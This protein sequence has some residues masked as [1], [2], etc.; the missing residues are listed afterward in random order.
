MRRR[1]TISLE[2]PD[3]FYEEGESTSKP[4]WQI[5]GYR[6]AH[7]DFIKNESHVIM[8]GGHKVDTTEFIDPPESDWP[9]MGVDDYLQAW[10]FEP[11][12]CPF[13]GEGLPE[14]VLRFNPPEK[15]ATCSD[16]GYYCDTC[17]K[18][19]NECQYCYYEDFGDERVCE[20]GHIY[21]RH[22]DWAENYR[23]GCKYCHCHM[24]KE[25]QDV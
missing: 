12:Y 8:E 24:F 6:P 14:I 7:I 15:I 19:L 20:C 13:C 10:A 16:G 25:R 11:K 22:F 21:Y 9:E 23:P 5:K 1:Q 17:S 18:R 4:T 2:V 3:D